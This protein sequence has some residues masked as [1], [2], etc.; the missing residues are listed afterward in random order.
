VHLSGGAL[1]NTSG[2]SQP[3]IKAVPANT[4]ICHQDVLAKTTKKL[5]FKRRKRTG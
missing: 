1:G 2:F 3:M 5:A 4:S